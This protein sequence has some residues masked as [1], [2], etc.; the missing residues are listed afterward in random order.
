MIPVLKFLKVSVRSNLI[1]NNSSKASGSTN[2]KVAFVTDK[3]SGSTVS[4]A[5]THAQL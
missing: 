3:Q 4:P 2:A 1:I 5:P